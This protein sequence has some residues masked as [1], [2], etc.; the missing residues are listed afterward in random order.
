MKIYMKKII[1]VIISVLIIISLLSCNRHEDIRQ[2]VMDTLSAISNGTLDEHSYIY[3]SSFSANGD[4]AYAYNDEITQKIVSSV[5]YSVLKI[6]Q[7]GE[8]AEAEI[9]FVAPDAYQMIED[10]VLTMQEDNIDMLLETFSSQLDKKFPTKEFKVSV[11]LKLINEHWYLVPNSQL[12]N[13]FSGGLI[14]KYSMMG[15]NTIDKLL[16]VEDGNE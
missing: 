3:S 7:N 13:A 15:E 4:E 16:E 12:A 10:I 9:K 14:E 1:L 11:N 2:D 8:I 5:Q 6:S